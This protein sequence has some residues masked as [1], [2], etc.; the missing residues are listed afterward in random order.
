MIHVSSQLSCKTLYI[1]AV[2]GLN[3][4]LEYDVYLAIE[5]QIF[6]DISFDSIQISRTRIF[7]YQKQSDS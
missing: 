2:D 7:I 1:N 6:G 4:I 3:F 5:I